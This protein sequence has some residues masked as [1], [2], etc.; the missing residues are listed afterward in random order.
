MATFSKQ[1]ELPSLP[2]PDLND[3]LNSY[4]KSA[5]VLLN[6]EQKRKTTEA[7]ENFRNSTL[8][9][10]LQEALVKRSKEMRNWL[11]EW[12]YDS[13]N[14]VRDPLTP[15]LS[16]ASSSSYW[17]PLSG[18]QICRAAD[19]IFHS[20]RFRE[21]IRNGTLPITRSR[22][23]FWDMHQYYCLFNATRVPQL[24]KDRIYRYF[25]TEAEGACPSHITVL[26]RGNIWCVEMMKNGQLLTPDELH[27]VLSYIDNHSLEKIHCIASLTTEHRDTW[28]K[29]R[30]LIMSM[31]E[32]NMK[33]IQTIEKSCFCLT[34]TDN[35]YESK[36]AQL[37]AALMGEARMQWADKSWNV[38]VCKDG[39]VLLQG[40]HSNVDAIVMMHTIDD[41]THRSRKTI[42][43]AQNVLFGA[44]KLLEFD[45]GPRECDAI[46]TAERNF[47][48]LKQSFRV[49]LVKFEGYGN[50]L[51]RKLNLYMDTVVQIALQLAFLRTHGSFA[52]IYETASTRKFY[53]GRTET[54]R[55]CTHEMVAFGQAII[56]GKSKEEQQQL[57][58]AA[59]EEHNRLMDECMDG[60]GID[61]HL[62]GLRK[63]LENFRN[64]GS[65]STNT[66]EIFTD[67]AW[68]VS[69]GDGNYLL[70]TSFSGYMAENDEVGFYGFV[71]AMRPDGYGTF[72]RIGR[73]R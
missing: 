33:N 8:A 49:N 2:V 32:R 43:Q 18:S 50:D 34:L 63:T 67:E 71:T 26:C 73:N 25:K 69:G 45:L 7:V 54:V 72:Y 60:R 61:R 23:K 14:E 31:S 6:D 38:I 66:P 47:N 56:D 64:S 3:T 17:Y 1:D 22:G 37:H 53:H 39:Q 4:L 52:P 10:Q 48:I 46:E 57:F 51:A 13:Y 41:I 70:S 29:L 24:P 40:D 55:G 59:Y 30:T 19:V 42:W 62:Y 68:K 20:M 15:Y 28:A 44:P 5:T 16:I 65:L 9:I 58:F 27:H 36:P 35:V 11:E 12:W 21:K